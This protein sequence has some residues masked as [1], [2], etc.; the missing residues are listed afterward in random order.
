MDMEIASRK[1]TAD[2]IAQATISCSSQKTLATVNAIV[3]KVMDI[4]ATANPRSISDLPIPQ[5]EVWVTVVFDVALRSVTQNQP[6][7][8]SQQVLRSL[9]LGGAIGMLSPML[10][11]IQD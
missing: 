6:H 1:E 7:P 9:C 4:I 2:A 10:G 5:S 8:T 3:R 11:R